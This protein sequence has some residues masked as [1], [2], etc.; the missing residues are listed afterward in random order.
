MR[1]IKSFLI[2]IPD[3]YKSAIVYTFA[4]IFT[5]GLAIV[6]VPIFTRLMS[7]EE[8]GTVNV[9]NS[10]YALL[11]V[12]STLSLTSGGFSVAMKEY[13]NNRYQYISS[14]YT[15]TILTS[16]VFLLIFIIDTSFWSSTLKL[17]ISLIYLM[18]FGFIATPARDFWFAKNR[19]EYKYKASFLVS[20]SSAMIATFL[21]VF[22]VMND[23]GN[24]NLAVVRLFA[25]N[26]TIY[27]SA[28]IIGLLLLKKGNH[29]IDI[30][31]WKYSLSLSIPLIGYS[32]AAQVLNV[33]DRLMINSMVG[34]S[35]VGIYG[36]L[37]TISSISV[38]VWNAI[39][40]SFVPY[41]FRNI[42][43]EKN[44]IKEISTFL[45]V[46]FSALSIALT[47]LG[48]EVVQILSTDEYYKA[49]NIVPP[50]SA[51]VYFI[52]LSNLYSNILVYYKKTKLI[53]YGSVIAAGINIVLNMIFI[54]LKGFEVAAYT[55][56]VSYIV[57]AYLEYYW[58]NAVSYPKLYKSIYADKQIALLSII[59]TVI[60]LFGVITYQTKFIRITILCI[61][62]LGYACVALR[63]IKKR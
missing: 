59:T 30:N 52:S 25:N 24:S 62:I 49:I 61:L 7:T 9:Y 28:F 34:E 12:I 56:L 22:L 36:T 37:Y 11:S 60:D 10:W 31:I 8:I 47:Y 19:Y 39:N 50:I 1:R 45:L 55:T 44:R 41:L 3:S 23:K 35:A 63:T 43:N 14:V 13:E 42:E 4:T 33:S 46:S 20:V 5:R 18:I 26:I 29:F 15:L 51:G 21:S 27:G 32:F 57:L 16:L 48:P 2:K 38:M 54:P 58:A 6:T 40:S 17:P 53:M